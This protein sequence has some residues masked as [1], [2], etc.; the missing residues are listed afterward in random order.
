ML[1]NEMIGKVRRE[2]AD[3]ALFVF[4]TS[5]MCGRPVGVDGS[6][7]FSAR[8]AWCEKYRKVGT[9]T[10]AVVVVGRGWM[11]IVPCGEYCGDVLNV[12]SLP[13]L[14]FWVYTSCFLPRNP[15]NSPQAFMSVGYGVKIV[16][17]FADFI[18][19]SYLGR[20]PRRCATNCIF[21]VKSD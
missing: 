14:Y 20:T 17:N 7:N 6:V 19:C 13:R 5:F 4:H 1:L 18:G 12:S 21:S 16:L 10:R 11:S 8:T 3:F 15:P 2:E 9:G